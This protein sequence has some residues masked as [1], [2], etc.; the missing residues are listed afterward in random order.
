MLEVVY[1][2]IILRI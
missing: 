1:N 2:M